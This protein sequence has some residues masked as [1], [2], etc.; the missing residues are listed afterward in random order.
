M[1]KPYWEKERIKHEWFR[2]PM[3]NTFSILNEN[4]LISPYMCGKSIEECGAEDLNEQGHFFTCHVCRRQMCLSCSV[5]D[6]LAERAPWY[7]READD[8]KRCAQCFCEMSPKEMFQT[9][10]E[11]LKRI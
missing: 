5:P 8:P 2:K 3:D 4:S 6:R 9:C 11:R 10:E 7:Q 1:M